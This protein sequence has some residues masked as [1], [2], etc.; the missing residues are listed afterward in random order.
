MSHLPR[1]Y[2]LRR[3]GVRLV[4]A[5][6]YQLGRVST[7]PTRGLLDRR[8]CLSKFLF[9]LLELGRLAITGKPADA[10]FTIDN[11]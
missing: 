4:A 7:R 5:M 1:A 9:A 3:E 8:V 2:C 6:A 10:L 11:T